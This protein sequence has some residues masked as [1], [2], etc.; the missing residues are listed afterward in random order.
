[1]IFIDANV[2]RTSVD[3]DVGMTDIEVRTLSSNSIDR[4]VQKTDVIVRTQA[5]VN[6]NTIWSNCEF[7]D[8]KE[9]H[10]MAPTLPDDD[11]LA[12]ELVASQ[13]RGNT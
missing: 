8:A 4:E 5:W 12:R 9:I 7:N 6:S 10:F 1:M 11:K 13:A 3:Q 2:L